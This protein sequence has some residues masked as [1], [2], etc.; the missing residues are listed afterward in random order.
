LLNPAWTGL[1]GEDGWPR[2]LAG[3]L[4]AI[5]V[6][7][8]TLRGTL[9]WDGNATNGLGV[10]K[11]INIEGTNGSSVTAVS[12][13]VYGT[14][15][16]FYKALNDHR[17]EAHGAAGINPAIGQ[18]YYIGWRTKFVLPTQADLNAIFQWKAYG[19]PMLQNYPITIAPGGGALNLNQFNPTDAGG[20]TFLWSTPL[21]R[22][23]LPAGG[24]RFLGVGGLRVS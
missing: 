14:V 2:A 7:P 23:S 21:T 9:L 12:D 13:P 10:F 20:Q 15:W 22:L 4:L 24:L 8:A 18:T 1:A 5:T 6:L 11:L 17:C 16:Q 19:T 3:I